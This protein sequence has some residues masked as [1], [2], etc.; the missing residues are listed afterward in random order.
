MTEQEHEYVN[1][2]VDAFKE[3][4]KRLSAWEEGFME[5]MAMRLEKYQV[6]TYISPK[7]WGIIE[8]VAKKLDIERSP[9]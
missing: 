6:D 8:K 2:V 3:A 5:D 9:L 1:A 4:P 7:Q